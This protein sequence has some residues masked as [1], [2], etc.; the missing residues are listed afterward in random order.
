MPR[1]RLKHIIQERHDSLFQLKELVYQK[2]VSL[3]L[4]NSQA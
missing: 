2:I 4:S 3:T 1:L